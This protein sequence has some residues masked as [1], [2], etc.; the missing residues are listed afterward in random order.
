MIALLAAMALAAAPAKAPPAAAAPV[1]TAS[2]AAEKAFF[3]KAAKTAGV[4]SLPG[5]QYE[6]LT[7]GPADGRHPTGGDQLSARYKGMLMDG[8]VF[9]QSEGDATI[10]FQLRQVIPGWQVAMKLMRP[11][12]KWR[13]YVPA[14]MAYGPA[15]KP[16]IPAD[17][18]LIFEVE[19]VSVTPPG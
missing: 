16:K 11:G 14:Y 15:A 19:L 13:I 3:A 9:D 1:S 5:L 6:V 12:D 18:P 2:T 8:T 7:A 10:D 4:V 17:S